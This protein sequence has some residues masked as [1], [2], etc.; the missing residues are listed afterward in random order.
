MPHQYA[1][2]QLRRGTMGCQMRQLPVQV[3]AFVDDR[4]MTGQAHHLQEAVW[5]T[6]DFDDAH[7]FYARKKTTVW[8]TDAKGLGIH[9]RDGT[10]FPKPYLGLPFSYRTTSPATWFSDI[11]ASMIATTDRAPTAAIQGEKADMRTKL[12]PMLS[13]SATILRPTVAQLA[14]LRAAL[15]TDIATSLLGGMGTHCSIAQSG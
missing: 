15:R 7:G 12:L 3:H 9:W 6:E 5:A 2:S 10:P 14:K 4:I 1:R 13:C 11:V 8:T